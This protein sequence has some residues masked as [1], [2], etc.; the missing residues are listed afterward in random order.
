MKIYI[1]ADVSLEPLQHQTVTL[2]VYEIVGSIHY[3]IYD[4][5]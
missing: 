2:T 3:T 1:P 5:A 4:T